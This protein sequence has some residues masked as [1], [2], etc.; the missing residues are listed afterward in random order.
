MYKHYLY[1]IKLKLV[2]LFSF[3]NTKLK[4]IRPSSYPF[5]SGDTF[6]AISDYII[7][8]ERGLKSFIGGAYLNNNLNIIFISAGFIE[9]YGKYNLLQM[10]SSLNLNKKTLIIHNGDYKNDNFFLKGISK[11]FKKV[12]CVNILN[13]EG[14]IYPIPIGIEN[15]YYMKN[16]D[17]S[18][19]HMYRTKFLESK[20]KKILVFAS[21]RV[22]TNSN[23]RLQVMRDIKASRFKLEN[24]QLNNDEYMKKLSESYFCL[25]PPGNGIDC[26]R[27]W[28]ALYLGAIP[29]VLK[30]TLAKPFIENL[31]ILEV[32]NYAD[33]LSKSD[34]EMLEV[35]NLVHKNKNNFMALFDYWNNEVRN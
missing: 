26:H 1:K 11:N 3:G 22:F 28:E 16:G 2:N 31:P 29:V 24:T 25:S 5:I 34:K 23:I 33:F 8:E 13:H 12:F 20:N 18:K 14:N 32:D 6:R 35:Y 21:F 30:N 15:L 9:E 4:K 10:F 27:T 19:F 7:E 17:I